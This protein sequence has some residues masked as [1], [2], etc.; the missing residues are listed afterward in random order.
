MTAGET[1]TSADFSSRSDNF[2]SDWLIKSE[3]NWFTLSRSFIRVFI[4]L[5][6][7]VKLSS[8]ER[9]FTSASLSSAIM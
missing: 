6:V 4:D 5:L 3:F 2:L 9:G 8:A 7:E 1:E